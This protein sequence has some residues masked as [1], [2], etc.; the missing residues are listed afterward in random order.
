MQRTDLDLASNPSCYDYFVSD[1]IGGVFQL[2]DK[3]QRFIRE[4]PHASEAC[5]SSA[6][7][8]ILPFLRLY[9]SYVNDSCL[10]SMS[11]YPFPSYARSM[12]ICAACSELSSVDSVV[13]TSM[14][15]CAACSELSSVEDT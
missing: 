11:L 5:V 7:S 4:V 12:Y 10:N 6:F 1:V 15:I 2:L 8:D 9:T 3:L 13:N 14:Y